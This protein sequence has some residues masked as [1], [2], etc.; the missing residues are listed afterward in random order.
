MKKIKLFT[1]I[2]VLIS[3]LGQSFAAAWSPELTVQGIYSGD[4]GM[5]EGVSF[6]YC[7]DGRLYK[8]KMG[9]E[10]SDTMI[11]LA[12]N[13]L[14]TGKKVRIFHDVDRNNSMYSDLKRILILNH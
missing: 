4:Y 11:A 9:P 10:F 13:A 12:I 5:P 6:V 2:A 8:F 7:S 14:N 1:L 3:G